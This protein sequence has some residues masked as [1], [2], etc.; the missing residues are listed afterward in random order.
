MEQSLGRNHT[1]S[2][3][4]NRAL[5]LRLILNQGPVSRLTL[6]RQTG[7]SPAALTVLTGAL[8]EEGLLIELEDERD[9]FDAPKVGRRSVPLDLN[10]YVGLALG[11]HITP[12]MVRVG[13]VDLK[14]QIVDQERL[15]A[16]GENPTQTLERIVSSAHDLMIRNDRQVMGVG[17][18]A[19][20]VVDRE[21]GVNLRALSIHWQNVPI[22][23]ELEA[24]LGLPVQI[25]NNVRGMT[26]AELLFGHGRTHNFKNIGLVYIGTGVGGGIVIDGEL[27]WGSGAAAGEIGH[28]II[29]RNGPICYC[30]AQGCVE[31]FAGE[32]AML[33]AAQ[34]AAQAPGLLNELAQGDPSQVTIEFLM[35]AAQ[36]GDT[37]ALQIVKRA[38]QA[39]GLAV[40]NIYRV[41]NPDT[42]IVAG[43]IT[44]LPVF[45]EAVQAE[46]GRSGIAPGAD[47]SVTSSSLGD[48]I[49]L[50]GAAALALRE[51][52]F[53]PRPLKISGVKTQF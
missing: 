7:L 49:G 41:L 16:P 40:A 14:G 5:I 31:Q 21:Q 36:Q 29:D 3:Y 37:A 48:N 6:A 47:L 2:K 43:R 50:V 28:M 33:N 22:K 52:L 46:A 9:T 18:G 10:T 34:Q 4:F 42:V 38:G 1:D 24:R 53:T 17:V 27:Y 35:E 32:A 39:T 25:D 19:V 44:R 30:G 8:L 11:I 51:F 15:G 20:G 13:L 23:A 26:L 45:L 12:R